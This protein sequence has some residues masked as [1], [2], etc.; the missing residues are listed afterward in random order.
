M[1]C[2]TLSGYTRACSG[3]SGGISRI[4]VFDPADFDFTQTAADD[5]YS[6]V[7]RRTGAVAAN[8]AL[9][10]PIPFQIDEAERTW[11]QSVKGLSVKYEHEVHAQLPQ[12]SN[13]LTK[14]LKSLTSAAGCC[15]LGLVIEHNDGKLFVMGEQYVNDA[16]IPRFIVNMDGSD[17]ATGKLFDDFNG[18]NVVFKAN[19]NRDLYEYSGDAADIIA[20]ES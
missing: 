2:V 5:P 6:V 9:M 18:A 10:F 1:L 16:T 3:V 7:A 4:W 15:G 17:G 19:Y 13:A 8:G 14:Y 20:L 12:L 11:K